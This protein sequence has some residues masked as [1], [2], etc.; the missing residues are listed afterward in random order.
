MSTGSCP[1]PPSPW[2][3][4]SAQQRTD[5]HVGARVLWL[6]S[7]RTAP[8]SSPASQRSKRLT[9]ESIHASILG[10]DGS[11]VSSK[12][13]ERAGHGL[14]S[15][16][17]AGGRRA[18]SAAA[19]CDVQHAQGV[20]IR[21]RALAAPLGQQRQRRARAAVPSSMR[22]AA[23]APAPAPAP[24]RT[25]R[26]S[27]R[28]WGSRCRPAWVGGWVGGWVARGRRASHDR[29]GVAGEELGQSV[30]A[31]KEGNSGGPAADGP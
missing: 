27:S 21:Q 8:A 12:V 7:P 30:R 5:V 14:R 6:P 19:T 23:R 24:R 16:G 2:T 3:G 31:C 20:P 18:V 10:D 25:G 11:Q 26:W 22:P 13:E 4:N 1:V 28:S 9:D 17:Q 29:H 15:S